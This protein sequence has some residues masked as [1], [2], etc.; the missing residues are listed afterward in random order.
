MG[1]IDSVPVVS[2]VKSLTQEIAGDPAGA[3]ATQQHFAYNNTFPVVSQI[4]SLGYYID[5]KPEEAKDLQIKFLDD[6]ERITN[7]I[8]VAGHIKG[9]VHYILGDNESGDEAMK[10]A[11]RS[12]GVALG[13]IG[14]FAMGGPAGAV[15]GGVAGGAAMDAIITESDKLIHGK[16]AS[17]YGYLAIK[18]GVED[19]NIHTAGEIFDTA[20]MPVFDGVGG[21]AGAKIGTG[22]GGIVEPA[23]IPYEKMHP[24]VVDVLPPNKAGLFIIVYP[25]KLK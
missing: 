16:N 3:L 22:E 11:S 18:D 7:S 24:S 4:A 8:P 19:G 25:L 14:G 5:G 12:T 21:L 15:A 23:E 13:G 20:M 6:A 1:N 10:A 2:Q 9:G 17:N